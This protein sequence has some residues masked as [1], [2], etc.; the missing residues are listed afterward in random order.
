MPRK[1]KPGDVWYRHSYI[2]SDIVFW[3]RE[4]YDR[5]D[6]TYDATFYIRNRNNY[7]ETIRSD[8][9]RQDSTINKYLGHGPQDL[10]FYRKLYGV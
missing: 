9:V 4:V 6:L 1:I 5:D 3:V 2:F 10:K 7:L 8:K